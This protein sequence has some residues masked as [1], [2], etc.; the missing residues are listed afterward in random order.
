MLK[1][2]IEDAKKGEANLLMEAVADIRR[3]NFWYR[4]F[5]KSL[6]KNAKVYILI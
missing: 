5:L 1:A 4:K 2:G 6:Y 3:K